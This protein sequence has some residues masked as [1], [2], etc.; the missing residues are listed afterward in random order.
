[1]QKEKIFCKHCNQLTN[2]VI[3]TFSRWHLKKCHNMSMREYYDLYLKKD[4]E[5]E[6]KVCGVETKWVNVAHGYRDHCS[7][8]CQHL[9]PECIERHKA[10]VNS[11]DKK[12]TMYVRVAIRENTPKNGTAN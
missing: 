2:Q 9:N 11:Y 4:N 7:S 6:C 1:M 5:G 10:G 12:K 3:D 8:K